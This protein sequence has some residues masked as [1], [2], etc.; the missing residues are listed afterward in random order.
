[1]SRYLI[2][3]L[4]QNLDYA[5][6]IGVFGGLFSFL[7][8]KLSR[9]IKKNSESIEEAIK[10]AKKELGVNDIL[11]DIKHKSDDI[12]SRLSQEE[13]IKSENFV[14]MLSNYN[15][16][17]QTLRSYIKKQNDLTDEDNEFL[18]KLEQAIDLVNDIIETPKAIMRLAKFLNAIH[19]YCNTNLKEIKE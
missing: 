6:I 12:T 3:S 19:S 4:L 11:N 16:N 13:F 15:S 9:Q 18:G 5:L 1:M 7:G 14:S 8:W 2:T 17:L 10:V